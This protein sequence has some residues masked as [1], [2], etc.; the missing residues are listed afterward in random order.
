MFATPHSYRPALLAGAVL[1][2]SLLASGC[3]SANLGGGSTGGGTRSSDAANGGA[4][5]SAACSL[6]TD[7][8]MTTA[9]GRTINKHDGVDSS[10][11]G[12]SICTYQ[13]TDLSTPISVMIFY[14]QKA[15]QLYL[16]T[17]PGAEHIDGLGD[18]AFWNSTLASLFVRKGDHGLQIVASNQGLLSDADSSAIRDGFK[19]LATSAVPKI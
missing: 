6:F 13:G 5:T 16:S 1:G 15:M 18:D 10:L 7:A 19:R 2:V 12:Q 17:E 9:A 4:G 14:N 11:M 8:E 3:G